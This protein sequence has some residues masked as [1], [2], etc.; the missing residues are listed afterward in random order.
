[1]AEGSPTHGQE[2]SCR[3]QAVYRLC[4]R[5]KIN[6]SEKT[7]GE[8][9]VTINEPLTKVTHDL[10]FACEGLNDALKEANAVQCLAIVELIQRTGDLLRDAQALLDAMEADDK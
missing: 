10:A 5:P 8:K 7:P 9:G 4:C 1:V 6:S 3:R 2:E